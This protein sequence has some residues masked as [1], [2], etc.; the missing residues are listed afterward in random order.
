MPEDVRLWEIANDDQLREIEKSKLDLE[1]RLEQWL[2]RD[3]SIL[4]ENLLVIGR[5][6]RTEFGGFIDLLCMDDAGDLVI[7]ELKRDK[8]PREITAQALDYA[9]WVTELSAERVTEIA[10]A[11]LRDQGPLDGAFKKRFGQ[12]LPDT[13]NEEHTILI[14]GSEIDSS[15]ERIIKYLSDRYDVGINAATFQYFPDGDRELL[16]RVFL[17]EPGETRPRGSSKR[18]PRLTYE[19]LRRLAEEHGVADLY[20]RLFEGLERVFIKRRTRSSV[21]FKAEMDGSR[22]AIINLI[23]GDSSSESG[24]RFQIYIHRLVQHLGIDLKEATK[25]VPEDREDWRYYDGA[26]DDWAGYTGF[27]KNSAEVD[28]LL[29]ALMNTGTQQIS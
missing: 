28:R 22:K 14:V 11:Y 13:L 6:V 5:Q 8:T 1:E 10:D 16:A 20:D 26:D 7:V 29:E 12:D 17:I 2:E 4:A 3:I 23:P 24:L 15:S 19:Q 21:S 27:F 9:S 25:L 18:N